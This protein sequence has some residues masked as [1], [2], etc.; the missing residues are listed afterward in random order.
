M[1]ATEQR[2][3]VTGEVRASYL[4]VFKPRISDF[5]GQEEYSLMIL[6]PKRDKATVN[7]INK[8]VAAA[9]EH[10]WKNK[11]PAKL[12]DPLRDGD[13]EFDLPDTVEVGTEP[14]ADHYFMNVRSVNGPG[15]VDKDLQPILDEAA[16]RSGD[17]CRVSLN[18]F[19]YDQK[20]NRGVSFGLNNV[21]VLRKGEPLG[22]AARPE[23]DFDVVEEADDLDFL[24]VA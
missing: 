17:Y 11:P 6:I 21:Q 12:R 10:K 20:G 8:A 7:K 16:F 5:S 22:G 14:Y 1:T 15:V 18:A 3:V 23:N 9:I 4:N 2:K 19:A 13:D 24:D